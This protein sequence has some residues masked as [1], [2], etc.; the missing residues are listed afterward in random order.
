MCESSCR[1]RRRYAPGMHEA[2]LGP[3]GLRVSRIGLGTSTFGR[4]VSAAGAHA[5]VDEAIALGV[6]LFD[7]AGV[8]GGRYGASEELLGH[9]LRGYRRTEIVIAS[10]VGFEIDA[11]W[12][13]SWPSPLD[14]RALMGGICRSLER[15][16]TDYLDLLQVHAYNPALEPRELR[17]SL[18]GAL[19][20][21]LVRAIGVSRFPVAALREL[22]RLML[23]AGHILTSHQVECVMLGD[24]TR[25]EEVVR[26]ST[27][28]GIGVIGFGILGGGMLTGKYVDGQEMSGRL[29]R[30]EFKVVRAR[31]PPEISA[32][33]SVLASDT[34]T[35]LAALATAWAL[36]RAE[37]AAVLLG[38]TSPHQL[39]E[40]I[41]GADIEASQPA[42]N[43]LREVSQGSWTYS[44]IPFD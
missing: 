14:R 31:L 23:E 30:R 33:L 40:A 4:E 35:P 38:A 22:N 19:D 41:G 24:Q 2:R 20:T 37:V 16:S 43:H 12:S 3:N 34:P 10:K 42:L 18:V 44:S 28:L 6:S 1:P 13:R 27:D 9:A 11:Q 8:Y 26:H 36:G 17:D 7:T 21:G 5:I 15:L 39:R 32:S 29:D 25:S